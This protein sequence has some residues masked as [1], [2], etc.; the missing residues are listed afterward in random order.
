MRVVLCF[1]SVPVRVQVNSLCPTC[2]GDNTVGV[3]KGRSTSRGGRG[4]LLPEN[5]IEYDGRGR[6]Y[7]VS[8]GFSRGPP[9]AIVP[10][11]DV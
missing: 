8:D 3:S 5:G 9:W 1:E 11:N 6:N 7:I 2:T 10:Y 4:Y